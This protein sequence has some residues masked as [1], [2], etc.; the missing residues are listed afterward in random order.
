MLSQHCCWRRRY[1]LEILDVCGLLE[2]LQV[3]EIGD[4]VRLVEHFLHGQIIEIHG[5]CKALYKLGGHVS[6]GGLAGRSAGRTSSSSSKRE[7]P[8]YRGT[9]GDAVEAILKRQAWRFAGDARNMKT[10]AQ[11]LQCGVAVSWRRRCEAP[12]RSRVLSQLRG[13]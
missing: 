9:S 10:M 11:A 2:V 8:P 4:K 5:I 7:Y 3:A 1:L 12:L 13:R 6:K